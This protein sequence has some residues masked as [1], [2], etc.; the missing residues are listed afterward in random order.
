VA[1]RARPDILLAISFLCTHVAIPSHQDQ[2]K[3]HRLLEY[4]SGT[5][6]MVLTLGAD[7][8]NSI[9]T[10]VDAS[11]AVL[12]DMKSHMGGVMSMG[13]GVLTYKL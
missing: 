8:L 10:W 12:P 3:L 6:D 5:L 2:L 11:Y 13:T 7:N 4:I 1:T 9:C